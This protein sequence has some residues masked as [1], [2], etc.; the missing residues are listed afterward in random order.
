MSHIALTALEAALEDIRRSPADAGTVELIVCRPGPGERQVMTQA[1]LRPGAG[2]IGDS[3]RTRGSSSTADGSAD[4]DAEM[5]LMNARSAAAIAGDVSRWPLAGDQLYVDLDLSAANLP[6]GSH[7][8]VGDAVLELTALP[9]RG[10][11]KF[12]RRFGVD[13]TRFINSA[14]GREL[15]LRGVN[16]RIVRGGVVRPGD[17]IAPLR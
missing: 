6:P 11:G 8:A 16:A 10:C 3:W 14:A 2:L 12:V 1:V 17:T 15:N 5:T 7:V 9:H 13:A 4:P